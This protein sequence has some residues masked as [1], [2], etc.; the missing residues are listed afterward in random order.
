MAL[1]SLNTHSPLLLVPFRLS[2][3][4]LR[5]SSASSLFLLSSYF[6]RLT[7]QCHLRYTSLHEVM[8]L[9]PL[10]NTRYI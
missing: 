2:V 1:L 4:H 6:P 8:V 5:L 7:V 3:C 10:A 9:L